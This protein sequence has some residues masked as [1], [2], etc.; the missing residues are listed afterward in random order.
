MLTAHELRELL[1]YNPA[2]GVFRWRVARSNRVK[3]GQET[4]CLNAYGYKVIGI[5]G[6]VLQASRLA[7]LYTTGA[8]P[9]H[10]IDHING[11]PADNRWENLRAATRSD[12]Q[13]NRRK[14][15]NNKSGFKGVHFDQKRGKWRAR[16]AKRGHDVDL[17]FFERV[18]D[19]GR[20]YQAA[21]GR[22]HGDFARTQ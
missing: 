19:A 3:V 1:D 13:C 11:D 20:A 8:W 17:G 4:G 7:W 10:D 12:N 21:A 16:I 2:T 6:R 15:S 5:H 22:V 18:E 9:E 14:Q